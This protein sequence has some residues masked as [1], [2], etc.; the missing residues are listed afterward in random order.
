MN[1]AEFGQTVLMTLYT[2]ALVMVSLYGLHRYV[3]V[4]L[5]YRHRKKVPAPAGHFDD[6]PN[7]TIQLPMYNERLVAKR[8]IAKTCQIDYPLD[9]LQIQ[10][11]DDS[12]DDTV[13]I[14]RQAVADA[15]A[16]EVFFRIHHRGDS[17]FEPAPIDS[18][19]FQ[20]SAVLA[21]L[22]RLDGRRDER[23]HWASASQYSPTPALAG[24][25]KS[26]TGRLKAR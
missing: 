25:E 1:W 15:R 6:L 3:I 11:L 23:G 5:Y 8:I 2:F 17:C 21:C 7:V 10:V 9:R 26:L 13:D 19:G 12:T 4:A 24:S 20:V 16:K 14:A 22:Y 18:D